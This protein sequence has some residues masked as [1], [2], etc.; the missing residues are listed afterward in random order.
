[1]VVVVGGGLCYL[2]LGCEDGRDEDRRQEGQVGLPVIILCSHAVLEA[3]GLG[4]DVSLGPGQAAAI[5]GLAL[6]RGLNQP[7]KQD[8][9]YLG[10]RGEPRQTGETSGNSLPKVIHCSNGTGENIL[11][12]FLRNSLD[13][14]LEKL[15]KL[16]AR[17][18]NCA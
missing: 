10:R 1:M 5:T 6:L 18:Y 11:F 13:Q 4:Q 9:R 15:P 2:L 3:F 12:P 7:G 17:C 8:A 16:I 14:S